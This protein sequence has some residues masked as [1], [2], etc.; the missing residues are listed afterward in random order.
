MVWKALHHPNVLLLLG[1]MVTDNWLVMISECMAKG[2]I[3]AFVA[4]D[5]DADRLG[6]ACFSFATFSFASDD[7]M[8]IVAQRCRQG[9]DIHA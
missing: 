6:P 5:A 2:T 8:T 9:V 3:N 1:V 7:H 4:T